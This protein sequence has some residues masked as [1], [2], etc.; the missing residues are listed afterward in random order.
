MNWTNAWWIKERRWDK[1]KMEMGLQI[2]D[3]VFFNVGRIKY[4]DTDKPVTIGVFNSVFT[5]ANP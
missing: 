5:L 3:Y 1:V 4:E 2:D